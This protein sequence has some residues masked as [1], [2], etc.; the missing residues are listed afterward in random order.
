MCPRPGLVAQHVRRDGGARG[1]PL[2]LQVE[3]E[4]EVVIAVEDEPEVVAHP[5]LGRQLAREHGGVRGERHRARRV[6][7]LEQPRV[8]DEGVDERRADL[9]VAVRRQVVG[10]QRVDRD[11]DDGR[12]RGRRDAPLGPPAR[13]HE[14]AEQH[15]GG[16][17]HRRRNRR[18]AAPAAVER[19]VGPPPIPWSE[20]SFPLSFHHVPP[21]PAPRIRAPRILRRRFG[22]DNVGGAPVR[23]R[24]AR[25]RPL[26][27]TI[28][29]CPS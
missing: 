1:V 14:E 25:R 18:R 29:P 20:Y 7:V 15:R 19:S 11:Q 3:G 26:R 6:G 22:G 27:A 16:H 9:R 21:W 23:S 2:L 17:A 10:A 24:G 8:F 4:V 28:R 5:V 12:L 13:D